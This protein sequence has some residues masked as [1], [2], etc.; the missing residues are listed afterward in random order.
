MYNMAEIRFRIL[1]LR[2]KPRFKEKIAT[3]KYSFN[4]SNFNSDASKTCLKYKGNM[5]SLLLG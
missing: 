2:K 3:V 1:E 5:L 4:T